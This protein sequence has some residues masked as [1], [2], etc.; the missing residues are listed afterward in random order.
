MKNDNPFHAEGLHTLTGLR[1]ELRLQAHL[2]TAEMNDRWLDAE[3]RW[4]T[5]QHDVR[6]AVSHSR[7]ELGDA[8]RQAVQSLRHA[9]GELLDA[10]R[11]H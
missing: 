10:L 2:F 3:Q 11:P 9:Y 7:A 6:E 4:Q 5:L 8:S 1:D